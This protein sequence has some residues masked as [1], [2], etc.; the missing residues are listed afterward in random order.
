MLSLGY[1]VKL[2]ENVDISVEAPLYEE[3][4]LETVD[5]FVQP[6]GTQDHSPLAATPSPDMYWV[7][8]NMEKKVNYQAAPTCLKC[9]IA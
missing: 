4:Q 5:L 6:K 1:V 3:F 7:N 2:S 9:T 8:K